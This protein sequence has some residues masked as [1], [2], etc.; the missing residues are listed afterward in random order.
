MSES[1]AGLLILNKSLLYLESQPAWINELREAL[2]K[3]AEI[4]E[5]REMLEFLFGSETLT[6]CFKR[7]NQLY[8]VG[9]YV[10]K[11]SPD[12]NMIP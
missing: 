4:C 3:K 9:L 11:E 8:L 10:I 6:D 1:Q 12:S 2:A 7:P 5:F